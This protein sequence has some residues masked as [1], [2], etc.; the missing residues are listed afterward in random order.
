M[1]QPRTLLPWLLWLTIAVTAVVYL[2]GL[3]GPFLFDDYQNLVQPLGEGLHG[4]RALWEYVSGGVSGPLG[5]PLSLLSFAAN[6][7]WG[8]LQTF[9]FKATNLALHLANGVLVY[10]LARRLLHAMQPAA[11]A[12]LRF[13]G[14]IASATA[15]AWLLHPLQLS[16]VLYV[17]QRMTSLSSF[18]CLLGLHAYLAAR[19]RQRRPLPT[20]ARGWLWFAVP[21][22]L[23][24]AMLAKESGALLMVYLFVLELCLLRFT[25]RVARGDLLLFHGLFV[26]LPAF[27][28]VAYLAT[29]AGWL[30]AGA[31]Y[32]GYSVGERLLT[33]ARVLWFYQ[34]MLWAPDLQ[35]LSLFHDD[36]PI[37]RGWLTPWTT[38]PAVLAWLLALGAFVALRASRPWIAF[39]IG[40]FLAGHLLESTIVMLEPVQLHR[41]YLAIFGPLLA[42]AAL[43]VQLPPAWRQRAAGAAGLWLLCLAAVTTLRAYQ[44]RDDYTIAFSEVLRHPDSPRANYEAGRLLSGIAQRTDSIE[45]QR[46][47]IR[48]LWR[49]VELNP[50]DSSALAALMI[51]GKEPDAE[52]AYQALRERLAARRVQPTDIPFLKQLAECHGRKECSIPAERM[53]GLFDAVLSRPQAD[54]E[55]A[56]MLSMLALYY[57]N[58]H[59]DL[60]SCVRLMQEAISLQPTDAVYR[61]NLANALLL[62]PDYAAAEAALD[63]A[64]RLDPW[65]KNGLRSARL[66]ADLR[67]FRDAARASQP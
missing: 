50:R 10:A 4:A 57:A 39:A 37:S 47:A 40:W 34:K 13:A 22:C 58:P 65:Q 2:P 54:E 12:N 62:L 26:G 43:L 55:R 17:V 27:A 56:D 66:R 3:H 64:D 44:W 31:D 46:E 29:H 48:Y 38:L 52:R 8:G 19:E 28:A 53:F 32:R 11:A 25:A 60:A 7:H 15:A 1:R 42:V 21:L 36:F 20:A 51:L 59:N 6:A 23:L 5:R 33:E 35:A 9:G 63:A 45:V 14:L 30:Q 41:N 61:L 49:A 16:S 67:R 24:L 18:F